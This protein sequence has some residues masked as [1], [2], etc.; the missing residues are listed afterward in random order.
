MRRSIAYFLLSLLLLPVSRIDADEFHTSPYCWD[1]AR[2]VAYGVSQEGD[3]TLTR[4]G[5]A[6]D[7]DGTPSPNGGYRF[8]VF[9][10]GDEAS[11]WYP[12]VGID[13]E[14]PYL[15]VLEFRATDAIS[16]AEWINEQLIYLRLWWG[17]IAGSD[18]I[19]DVE[20]E[21]IV[22]QQPFIYGGLAFQQFQQCSDPEFSGQAN[23]Q[24]EQDRNE[25]P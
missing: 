23:C 17:R 8:H 25:D 5:E 9:E 19:V 20:K 13:I 22:Y 2:I 7:V 11:A 21:R 16:E 18:F 4:S 24:C 6:L 14:R 15:L 12:R 3:V 10:R 1:E